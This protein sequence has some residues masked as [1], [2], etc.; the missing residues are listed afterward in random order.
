MDN[1][2]LEDDNFF[3]S[4]DSEIDLESEYQGQDFGFKKEATAT[5][6]VSESGRSMFTLWEIL[7]HIVGEL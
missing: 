6:S 1:I 3:P 5:T 7:S 2:F 4:L